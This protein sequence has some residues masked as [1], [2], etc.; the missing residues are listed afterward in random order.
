MDF[1]TIILMLIVL[2]YGF[3]LIQEYVSYKNR[4]EEI[5]KRMREL[6]NLRRE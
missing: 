4:Q 3:I 2:F 5:D 6:K 1:F